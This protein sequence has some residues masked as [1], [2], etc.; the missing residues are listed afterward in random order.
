MSLLVRT[1]TA[2]TSGE[3]SR[4]GAAP[5][6]AGALAPALR[7]QVWAMDRVLPIATLTTMVRLLDET[8]AQP[9]FN[10]LVLSAFGAA[11]LALAAMGIYGLIAYTDSQR[12]REIGLRMALG[13]QS[14]R[15][16]SWSA[17]TSDSRSSA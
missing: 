9:G 12:T 2:E 7:E 17:R 1:R 14:R 13:A 5:E 4:T 6:E 15:L 3:P 10:M 8:M 16:A 11:G